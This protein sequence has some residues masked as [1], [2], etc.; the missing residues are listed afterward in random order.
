MSESIVTDTSFKITRYVYVFR[1]KKGKSL[2][3]KISI[4]FIAFHTY[5]YHKF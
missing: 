5:M 4:H 3:E 2:L 1:S